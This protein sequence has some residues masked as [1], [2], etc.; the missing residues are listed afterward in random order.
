MRIRYEKVPVQECYDIAGA[1]PVRTKWIDINKG[2][3]DEYNIGSRLVAQEY[4]QGK[5]STIFA[6]TPLL[7]AKEALLSMAVTEGIGYGDGWCY[8][9]DFIDIKRA[10]FYIC[11]I[12]GGRREGRILRKAKSI[13]VWN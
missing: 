13:D 7:E 3:E 4:S 6:A 9:L 12:T 10:Y 2:D 11:E 1:V 8:T 5:L